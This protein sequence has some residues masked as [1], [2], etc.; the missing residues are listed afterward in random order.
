MSYR[1]TD[2]IS[3]EYQKRDLEIKNLNL[4]SG[5][6]VNLISEYSDVWHQVKDVYIPND[7]Y[8]SVYLY[9]SVQS[10][11]EEVT[12]ESIYFYRI[13]QVV[14]SLPEDARCI[15]SKQGSFSDGRGNMNKYVR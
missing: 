15:F 14:K 4:E 9:V 10:Y 12:T 7:Y 13:R 5:D 3:K 6:W 11:S 8:G 2:F 1:D